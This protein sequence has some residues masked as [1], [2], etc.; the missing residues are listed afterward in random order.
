MDVSDRSLAIAQSRFPGV[1]RFEL[2]DGEGP[3]APDGAVDLAFSSCVF[4]HVEAGE[5]VG[6]FG[7]FARRSRPAERR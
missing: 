3:L 6:L 4:H 2:Y 5:H 1:A 7:G